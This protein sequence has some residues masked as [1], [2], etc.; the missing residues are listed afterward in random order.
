MKAEFCPK[1]THKRSCKSPCRPVEMH[2]QKDNLTVF[3]KKTTGNGTVLYP[4]SREQ[5]ESELDQK[6]TGEKSQIS[7]E[8][9][10]TESENPFCHYEPNYRQTS[11]FIKRFFGQWSYADIAKA[12][13][14]SV[15]AARKLNYAG[16]QRLLAVIIEMDAVRK[17]Q[18][19]EQRKK[20]NVAKS[21]RYLERNRD[22]VKARRRE[23]YA[24]NKDLI[25]A[26]RR[27]RYARKKALI[28]SSHSYR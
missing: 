3:E 6:F 1:C 4:R 2:L 24:R 23:H 12:H 18:T 17:A 13:N 9:F 16:V 27:K 15:E 5:R 7:L 26:K 25:N 20:S 8:A 21:K 22:K 10:S 28:Q 19:P 14:I 11:V